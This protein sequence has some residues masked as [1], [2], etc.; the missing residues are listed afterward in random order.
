MSPREECT[1]SPPVAGPQGAAYLSR[2]AFLQGTA[3]VLGGLAAGP[4][5]QAAE[6]QIEPTLRV[7]LVTDVH[8]ADKSTRIN[9]Y[10][11]DSL[12]KLSEAIDVFNEDP[13]DFAVHLG[14]LIDAG[15]TVEEELRHLNAIEEV[16]SR[17]ACTRHY[18]LGNHCVDGLTKNEFLAGTPMDAEH[19]CFDA[20]GF[21][22]IAVDS[23]F[24]E[25]G[26]PYGRRNFDWTDAN[27][28]AEQIG[29]LES[30]LAAHDGPA[31]ILAHQRL[32]DAGNYSVRNA[33]DVRAVMEEAGNVLAV[34]QGHSHSQ[35][36]AE[37]NGIHYCT[38]VAM[39]EGPAP[40][41]SAYA[42]LSVYEDTSMR[43]EGYRRQ[44]DKVL[45][46]L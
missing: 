12:D 30:E 32:D 38:Q 17:L 22:F 11:R 31:I 45:P 39:V 35:D 7:G 2:R 25:D 4:R 8:Y 40:D 24:R 34:F 5:L 43:I 26:E 42:L 21:R 10:Y 18:V 37:V 16:F 3:L 23:C 29:W 44:E 6:P 19:Y 33:A 9:R 46:E 20:K 14:D 15:E 13:P 1:Y 41:N 27:I 28:L 36:Y